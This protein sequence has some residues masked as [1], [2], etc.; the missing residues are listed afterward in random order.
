MKLNRQL[1][2]VRGVSHE[3]KYENLE[4]VL[5]TEEESYQKRHVFVWY[6]L[7]NTLIVS[8]WINQHNKGIDVR[9]IISLKSQFDWV[10]SVRN[11]M[12]T[13]RNYREMIARVH[14][15]DLSNY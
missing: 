15:A 2:N 10:L 11:P 14:N 13:V 7:I 6:L 5:T 9:Q 8:V 12:L 1:F 3:E 4:S